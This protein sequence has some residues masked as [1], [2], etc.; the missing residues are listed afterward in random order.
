ML[1][2][3]HRGAKGLA[4]ENTLEGLKT[5]ADHKV[6]A[7]EFDVRVTNDG[8]PVLAHDRT[9]GRTK[10]D[11]TDFKHLKQL[12]PNLTTLDEAMRLLK[13]RLPVIIEVKPGTD[14]GPVAEVLKDQ[15]RN[16]WQPADIRIASFD[17]AVLERAK[18]LLPEHTLVV[19]ESWSGLRATR[20]AHRLGTPFIS[21]NQKWLWSGFIKSMA[22]QGF[23]L[24]A[25]T[26]N[27]PGK[28][29]RWVA[30]GLHAVI[31]DYPNQFK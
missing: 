6:D 29:K 25:Y 5:A 31:T 23:K 28:A 1:I 11:R 4:A 18:Q 3:G 2:I 14:V 13:N 7:I 22:K 24:S 27:D 26:L 17:L 16:G 10:I 20:R 15:L 21:M 9:V 19:N 12:R 30:A 8:V